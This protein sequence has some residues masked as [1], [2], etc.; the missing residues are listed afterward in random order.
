VARGVEEA[1]TIE[2]A[3]RWIGVALILIGAA[4]IGAWYRWK[5]TRIW[6]PLDVPVSLAA[7]H[8]AS[9]Q[10]EINVESDYAIGI[11]SQKTEYPSEQVQCWL[12]LSC[13]QTPAVLL[14]VR[15]TIRNG[16]RVVGRGSGASLGSWLWGTGYRRG[17]LLDMIHLPNGRYTIELESISD[18]TALEASSP[19]LRIDER[20][21]VQGSCGEEEDAL[22]ARLVDGLLLYFVVRVY[23]FVRGLRHRRREALRAEAAR[24]PLTQPGPQQPFPGS[25]EIPVEVVECREFYARVFAPVRHAEMKAPF[26]WPFFRLSWIAHILVLFFLVLLLIHQFWWAA[27]RL[28]PKGLIVGLMKPGVQGQP[29]P[30]IPPI[31]I[32][33]TRSLVIVNSQSVAWELLETVLRRELA[34]RPLNWPVYIDGDPDLEFQWPAR[35]IDV[36]QG[37]HVPV[38]LL[39][40]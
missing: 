3:C 9:A 4:W 2:R 28:C 6:T 37:L 25:R 21:G 19:A 31:R 17:R 13:F 29:S 20:G 1:V 5:E 11:L 30:G 26:Q 18:G 34:L 7:G 24:W 15:W 16:D 33:V 39:T 14:Q 23:L 22:L 8:I 32:H 40:R 12:G 27:G 10:F 36:V 35:A 38:V